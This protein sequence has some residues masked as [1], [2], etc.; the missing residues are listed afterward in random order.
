L[1]VKTF[2]ASPS[3]KMF[4]LLEKSMEISMKKE[5]NSLVTEKSK[6]YLQILKT[7]DKE[8]ISSIISV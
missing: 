3:E 5:E 2:I 4:Q 7:G 8:L 1:A 6:Q